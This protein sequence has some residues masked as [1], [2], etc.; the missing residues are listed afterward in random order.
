MV[1]LAP[2]SQSYI[3]W[4]TKSKITFPET[5]CKFNTGAASKIKILESVEVKPGSN[6][7]MGFRSEDESREKCRSP[8]NVRMDGRK[9]RR[10]RKA[11]SLQKTNTVNKQYLTGGFD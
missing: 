1:V 7:L 4:C 2:L 10:E 5:V 3:L 9:R 6:M 11:K 8:I